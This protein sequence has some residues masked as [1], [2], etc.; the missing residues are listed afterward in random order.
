[1]NQR[2]AITG[3]GVIHQHGNNPR[4]FW[5]SLCVGRAGVAGPDGTIPLTEFNPEALLS[6]DRIRRMDR[7]S[8]ILT[9]AVKSAVNDR[10]EPSNRIQPEHIGMCVSTNLGSLDT[11]VQFTARNIARG[12]QRANPM[13]YPNTA[14]NAGTGYACIETGLQG[15]NNTLSGSGA[16]AEAWDVLSLRRNPAI[17]AAGM[18]EASR[19]RQQ[20]ALEISPTRPRPLSS[21]RDG[22]W[23]GEGAAALRIEKEDPSSAPRAGV[24]SRYAGYAGTF[25]AVG[26]NN[27][28][29]Q[30]GQLSRAVRQALERAEIPAESI[31]GIMVSAEGSPAEDAREMRA[32]ESVFG[33]RLGE[34]PVF[35]FAGA[36][37]RL[38]G[39][40]EAFGALCASLALSTGQ[41]PASPWFVP[42]PD[43]PK[44]KIATQA[45]AFNGQS[46]LLTITDRTGVNYAYL[47]EK[48]NKET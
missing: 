48:N 16:L 30:G 10:T 44:L 38:D 14:L 35:A 5:Q 42:D 6:E 41:W 13:E 8:Q 45:S 24:Y 33:R 11:I 19:P 1:M 46:V 18:E 29:P 26:L 32:L 12:P 3:L 36:L 21:Q 17:L 34:I 22:A 9:G 43:L 2:F 47:F 25:D 39:A 20:G 4:T 15:Y 7:V 37:G 31:G 40:A 27:N 28:D 23:M